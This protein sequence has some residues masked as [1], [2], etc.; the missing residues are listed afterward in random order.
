NLRPT[1]VAVL[2]GLAVIAGGCA[3]SSDPDN[4]ADAEAEGNVR[5]NFLRS[6]NEANVEGGD[7]TEEQIPDYCECSYAEMV[8]FFSDDFQG[9]KDLESDLRNDPEAV[10]IEVKALFEQCI[11]SLG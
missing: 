3:A 10:P 9:F 2:L 11:A 1:L 6:C 4:W 7:L 8:E 5:Q